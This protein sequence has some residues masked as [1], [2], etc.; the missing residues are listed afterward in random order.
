MRIGKSSNPALSNNALTRVYNTAESSEKMTI[1][2]TVNKM[3]LSLLM[4]MVAAYFSWSYIAA[5][6]SSTLLWVGAIGGFVLALVTIF[7]SEWSYITAPI[8]AVL[9]GL[10]LGGISAMFNAMLPGIVF[11]AIGLTFGIAFFL[12]IAYR[13]GIIK[14]TAKLKRGIIIATGGVA[15]FYL[16]SMIGSFFGGGINL[17]SMG[18]MGIGIQLVIVVIAALNLILDFDLIEQAAAQG[19]PKVMEWYGAFSIMVT[20][21]WLYLEILKLL[22]LLA[23]NRD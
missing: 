14:A 6:G 10:F 13:T 8:Y 4:L 2:G 20:L 15:V 17:G 11:Q 21:V 19:A 23:G 1:N 7:K 5:G 16:V 9:E 22:A 12:L 18:L 3:I